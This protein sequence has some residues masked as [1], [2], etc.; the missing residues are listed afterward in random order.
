MSIVQQENPVLSRANYRTCL[1]DRLLR[2]VERLSS[3]VIR[4]SRLTRNHAAK[5]SPEH[6]SFPANGSS[7]RLNVSKLLIYYLKNSGKSFVDAKTFIERSLKPTRD[8]ATGVYY[9]RDQST[10][11]NLR[12]APVETG[13]SLPLSDSGVTWARKCSPIHEIHSGDQ[14][15]KHESKGL[16]AK[17][18]M[19]AIWRQ[20]RVSS[21]LKRVKARSDPGCEFWQPNPFRELSVSFGRLLYP[22]DEIVS[23]K[24]PGTLEDRLTGHHVF[25]TEVPGIRRALEHREIRIIQ[26]QE[27]LCV[28]MTATRRSTANATEQKSL[29]DLE[30]RFRSQSE[31]QQVRLES[32]N[33][34]LEEKQADLLLPHE[35]ADL[36]FTTRTYLTMKEKF[37]PRIL[38]FVESGNFHKWGIHQHDR[39]QIL[40]IGIPQQFLSPDKNARQENDPEKL[41]DYSFESIEHR[42]IAYGR[43]DQG[44]GE[45]QFQSSLA[46]IDNGPLGGRRQEFR[47]FEDLALES[48]PEPAVNHSAIKALYVSAHRIVE[49]LR[50]ET[51]LEVKSESPKSVKRKRKI[52]MG[53]RGERS[54][55]AILRRQSNVVR[56][57][58]TDVPVK[59]GSLTEVGAKGRAPVRRVQAKKYAR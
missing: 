55:Q 22:P 18:T 28:R 5:A 11:A 19:A 40:A 33:L 36:R 17:E 48:V 43:P 8:V 13:R 42:S 24:V 52:A 10:L 58:L 2:E 1:N 4:W 9:D 27:E 3:T 41:V 23:K 26:V 31:D 14:K 15:V 49:D 50:V 44:R 38:N 54:Q 29:P 47:L 53:Y 21:A 56:R 51:R 12:S 6:V 35:Q 37:D 45:R 39:S 46:T 30:L 20:L 7:Q 59:P 16:I 25:C 57:R 32:V 34:I